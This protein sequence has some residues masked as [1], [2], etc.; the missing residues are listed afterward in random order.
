MYYILRWPSPLS[1]SSQLTNEPT[2][3][4]QNLVQETLLRAP[5]QAAFWCSALDGS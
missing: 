2:Y 1:Q 3:C 4:L 5:F